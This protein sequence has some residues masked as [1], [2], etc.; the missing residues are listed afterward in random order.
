MAPTLSLDTASDL[1]KRLYYGNNCY[2]SYTGR[3]YSGYCDTAW[4]RW[5]RWV[6]LAVIVIA[7]I[8][9]FF[10]FSCCTARRRRKQGYAPYRGTGWALGGASTGQYNNSQQYQQPH[11]MNQVPSGGYYGNNA[12]APP[13]YNAPGGANTD[14]YGGQRNDIQLQQPPQS[15]GGYAPPKGPPPGRE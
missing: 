1:T 2:D 11:N 15:Y 13:V 7:A 10:V 8:F 3:Y 4:N 14:Y 9:I 5:G 12:S 6:L